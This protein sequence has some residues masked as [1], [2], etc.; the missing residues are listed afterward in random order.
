MTCRDCPRYDGEKRICRDGKLNPHRYEQAQ[1][2]VKLFGLRVVCPFN[3]H[4]ERLI[5]NRS[6]PL[7]R[8]RE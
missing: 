5:Y 6:A 2:V 1:E 8:K 4:R 3:D 7:S